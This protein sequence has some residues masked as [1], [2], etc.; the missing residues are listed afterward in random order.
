MEQDVGRE[1]AADLAGHGNQGDAVRIGVPSR[2]VLVTGVF[3]QISP[4]RVSCS[5]VR[6]LPKVMV[7]SI[8]SSPQS[9]REKRA[10]TWMLPRSHPLR[11]AYM[12]RVSEVQAASAA[13]NSSYG[14]GPVSVPLLSSGSSA[15]SWWVRADFLRVAGV[16]V[17]MYGCHDASPVSLWGWGDCCIFRFQIF[18]RRKKSLHAG[19]LFP[20]AKTGFAYAKFFA[21]KSQFTMPQNAS[22]YFA[23]ALR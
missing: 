4:R 13:S 21:A 22:A 6:A 16:I 2:R 12:R 18:T 20:R 3:S 8:F 15:V 14:A 9:S 23:R 10:S 7:R 11:S 5:G 1:L 17:Q 19:R